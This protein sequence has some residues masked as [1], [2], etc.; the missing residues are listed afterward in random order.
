MPQVTLP[1]L[2]LVFFLAVSLIYITPKLLGFVTSAWK[3][4]VGNTY[5]NT[6]EKMIK[7]LIIVANIRMRTCSVPDSILRALKACII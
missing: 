3:K 6:A 5:S 2:F 1:H 7:V 4:A